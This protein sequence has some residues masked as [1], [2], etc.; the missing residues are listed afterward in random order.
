MIIMIFGYA[1]HSIIGA[2][3]AMNGGV[4]S[5]SAFICGISFIP[6]ALV[7]GAAGFWMI[8]MSDKKT[9]K[10]RLAQY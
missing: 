6:M 2:L 1:F 4:E 5:A 8:S 7:F 3:I 9:G 10:V